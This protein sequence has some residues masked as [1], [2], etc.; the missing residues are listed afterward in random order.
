MGED[1]R[2]RHISAEDQNMVCTHKN[3]SVYMCG[4]IHMCGEILGFLSVAKCGLLPR[5]L[6]IIESVIKN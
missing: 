6:I 3:P 2:G 4:E 1:S 5:C